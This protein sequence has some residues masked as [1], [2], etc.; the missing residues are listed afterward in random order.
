[1]ASENHLRRAYEM[2]TVMGIENFAERVPRELQATGATVRRRGLTPVV[3]L[4]AR[5]ARC[6]GWGLWLSSRSGS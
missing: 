2:L 5:R 1:M 4:A 6:A 3:E